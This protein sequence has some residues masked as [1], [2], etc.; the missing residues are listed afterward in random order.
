M[1]SVIFGWIWIKKSIKDGWAQFS[2]S[3]Y[4]LYILQ[5][6][7]IVV[8]FFESNPFYCDF[9]WLLPLFPHTEVACTT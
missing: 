2:K 1:Q 6:F 3:E 7:C 9:Y 8:K 4:A 5:H